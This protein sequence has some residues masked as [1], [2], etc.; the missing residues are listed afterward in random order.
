MPTPRHQKPRYAKATANSCLLS[1][2]RIANTSSM[3]P[4]TRKRIELE[5]TSTAYSDGVG[6]FEGRENINR[7]TPPN[8]NK[9]RRT[10]VFGMCASNKNTIPHSLSLAGQRL[11]LENKGR[12]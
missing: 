4:T 5:T 8:G 9:V 11:R 2:A 10:R 6:F 1:G 7:V 12:K 3:T